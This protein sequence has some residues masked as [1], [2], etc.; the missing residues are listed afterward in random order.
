M[1]HSRNLIT[2]KITNYTVACTLFNIII[3]YMCATYI[4]QEWSGA[5]C[6]LGIDRW[7]SSRSFHSAVCLHNPQ[8]L[9]M[10]SVATHPS[11]KLLVLWGMDQRAEPI[12]DIWLLDIEEMKWSQVSSL[13]TRCLFGNVLLQLLCA[14]KSCRVWHS[15]VAYYPSECEAT[16]LTIGGSPVNIFRY[17]DQ[18]LSEV[19]KMEFGKEC[20]LYISNMMT[21]LLMTSYRSKE[22]LQ[23]LFSIHQ[24]TYGCLPTITA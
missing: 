12:N 21:S 4:Q 14:A 5:I 9:A 6:S 16:V 2:S 23:K 19:V 22:S 1:R 7:P 15:S 10:P 18:R 3:I 8:A 24:S 17:H 13:A 11:Q 20:V